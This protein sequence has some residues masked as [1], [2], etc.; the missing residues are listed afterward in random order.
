MYFTKFP[1]I[2]YEF[3][4]NG[5]RV[6]KLVSDITA[7]VRF[8]KELLENITLLDEYDIQ[9]GET[10]EIISNKMYGSPMYH[11]VIMLINQKYDYLEDWPLTSDQLYTY[12]EEKYPGTSG[13]VHHYV[14]PK[15][16]IVNSDFPGAIPVTNFDYEVSL[17][18][19]KRRIRLLSPEML[20]TVVNQ[21]KTML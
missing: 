20:T 2:Y 15:G 12:I 8:R 11:W 16:F 9:E 7:N 19:S 13:S 18:E 1:T 5:T 3:D 10:P 4:I 6:L 21:F 14:S 17:N